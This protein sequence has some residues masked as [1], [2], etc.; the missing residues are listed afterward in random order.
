MD[1]P[2]S[3]GG[4]GFQAH[5]PWSNDTIYLDTSGCCDGSLQ[6]I[7]APISGLRGTPM[8]VF[9]PIGHHFVFLYNAGDKQIWIDGQ[10]LTDGSSSA[11]LALD[12]TDM[13]LGHDTIDNL[14]N[15]CLMDDFAAFSTAVSPTN[16]ALL[17]QG[18]VPTALTG[19]NLLAYWNFNDASL[20]TINIA[21][22]NGKLMI[23]YTGTLRLPPR[24]PEPTR[25]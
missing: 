12:F 15:H 14:N 8:T 22:A 13:Y 25:M 2:S 3:P 17:A 21:L 1:S 6:R 24:R 4:R 11:P 5:L 18:T 19:E 16:I 9:G 20:P 10:Q 7:S 23:T